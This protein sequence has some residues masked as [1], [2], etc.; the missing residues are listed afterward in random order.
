[1]ANDKEKAASEK[2]AAGKQPSFVAYSVR[3]GKDE[4]QYYDRVGA[5]F[6]HNDGQGHTLQLSA[7][8]IGGRIVIRSPWDRLDELNN[9]SRKTPLR[10]TEGHEM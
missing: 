4:K 7:Y 2:E 3:Q 6:P 8:P 5:A 1:M 9:G 10:E